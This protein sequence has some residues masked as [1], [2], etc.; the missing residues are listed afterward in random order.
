MTY[1]VSG[2]TLNPTQLQL[3][4]QNRPNCIPVFVVRQFIVILP[5]LYLFEYFLAVCIFEPFYNDRD[6][7]DVIYCEVCLRNDERA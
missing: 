7:D 4:L 1:I 2:G 6:T 5:S 3:V